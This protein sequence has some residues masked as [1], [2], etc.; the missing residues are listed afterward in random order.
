M[1]R[2]CLAGFLLLPLTAGSLGTVGAPDRPGVMRLEESMSAAE[3]KRCG[4]H[5]LTPA[6]LAALESWLAA[7]ASGGAAGASP[8]ALSGADEGAGQA[9][10]IVAFN[11]SNGKYHCLA[12]T[13]AR[14][15]TRNCVN[16]PLAQ[17]RARGVPCKVCRGSCR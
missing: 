1:K 8:R 17:A 9:A 16:M 3:F 4:L 5:K 11:V 2:L 12:C 15:C 6:E 13:W 10:E 14:R 7:R